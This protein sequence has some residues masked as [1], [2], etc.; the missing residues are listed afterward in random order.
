MV[1]HATPARMNIAVISQEGLDAVMKQPTKNAV[2]SMTIPARM[3]FFR[4][5]L[6][7]TM[8][9]GRYAMIAATFASSKVVVASLSKT[10]CA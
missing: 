1:A 10:F 2:K 9:T 4:P 6:E 3:V 5:I 7:A 8:P